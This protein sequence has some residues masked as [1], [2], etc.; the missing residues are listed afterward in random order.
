MEK[1][2]ICETCNCTYT[3]KSYLVNHF[4]SKKHLARMSA[5]CNFICHCGKSYLHKRNLVEHKMKCTAQSKLNN[6]SENKKIDSLQKENEELKEKIKQLENKPPI[7]VKISKR[8]KMSERVRKSVA[9]G[10]HEKC[11]LCENKLSRYFHIDHAVALRYGGNNEEENLQALCAECHT[12]KTVIENKKQK[13]IW[14]AIKPI[15]L[16]V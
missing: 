16:D 4:K 12:M 1:Q 15:L 13:M 10:Q 9:G 8:T 14:N 3:R 2:Y 6:T 11:A 5:T 7:I